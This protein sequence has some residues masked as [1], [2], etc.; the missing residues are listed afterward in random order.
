[1][2]S[3]WGFTEHTLIMQPYDPPDYDYSYVT[4]P[5]GKRVLSV[6]IGFNV[7]R[8][9]RKT[10]GLMREWSRCTEDSKACKEYNGPHLDQDTWS[11]YFRPKLTNVEFVAAPC[12]EA[13]GHTQTEGLEHFNGGCNGTLVAHHSSLSKPHLS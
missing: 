3:R 7:L 9:S 2:L 6:N 4:R 8:S 13:N 11:M 1:M 10:I 5:D 12:D